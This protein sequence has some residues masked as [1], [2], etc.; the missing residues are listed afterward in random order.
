MMAPT[1]I[2]MLA[3]AL[4]AG[5]LGCFVVWRRMAYFGDGLAHSALLGVAIG[6]IAGISNQVGM[7]L[8]AIA[9]VGTLL[10]LRTQRL[11][12][13]DTLLGIL[14]HAALSIGIVAMAL[15][16]FEDAEV[17]DYLLGSLENISADSLIYVVL[18]SGVSLGLLMRLW[19][20][21]LLMTSSEEL[22][23][24][25]GVPIR[26][27]EFLLMCLLGIVVA[28]AVQ[29]VGILLITSLLIIPAS[30]ARLIAGNPENMAIGGSIIAAL[31]M[32][33]G[34]PL[35]AA[36]ALPLGPAIVTLTVVLFLLVLSAR[37]IAQRLKIIN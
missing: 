34:L 20:G 28:T 3:L 4:L 23:H 30:T 17:H 1:L 25:E 16:G 24:A 8:M 11:L 29:I 31:C 9:F 7:I 2:T 19:P 22:A 33:G 35:A 10:W 27:Y 26:V 15:L 18:G 37:L 14:A 32:L 13:T 21:L 12:A 6:L 36:F 5:P